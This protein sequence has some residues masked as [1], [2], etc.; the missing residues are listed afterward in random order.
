MLFGVCYNKRKRIKDENTEKETIEK[1]NTSPEQK[2]KAEKN[3]ISGNNSG[4]A[5]LIEVQKQKKIKKEIR[6]KRKRN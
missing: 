3:Y 5:N 2:F 1:N 4:R 6:N